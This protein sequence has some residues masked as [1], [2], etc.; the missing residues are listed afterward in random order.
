MR[1]ISLR[2]IWYIEYLNIIAGSLL[3]FPTNQGFFKVS[4]D[5]QWAIILSKYGNADKDLK[6]HVFQPCQNKQGRRWGWRSRSTCLVAHETGKDSTCLVAHGTGKSCLVVN[7]LKT[8]HKLYF[9]M[10][11][12]IKWTGWVT[13]L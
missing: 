1:F 5:F 12:H 6:K 3:L 8:E 2:F 4:K 13:I 10:S 7:N 9:R 11:K